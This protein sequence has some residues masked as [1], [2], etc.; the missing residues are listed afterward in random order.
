MNTATAET[1]PVPALRRLALVLVPVSAMTILSDFLFWGSE[2]GVSVGIFFAITGLMLLACLSE[3]PK[4]RTLAVFAALLA[5]CVQ[6][7][8]EV[9]LSNVLASIALTL[10]LA[11]EVFQP[12]LAPLWARVSEVLFGLASAPARWLGIAPLATRVALDARLPGFSLAGGAARAVWVLAPALLLLAVFGTIFA[13]SNAVFGEIAMRF[14]RNTLEWF[15]RLDL[16]FSRMLFWALVSTLALGI[17]HGTRAPDSPRWWTRTLPRL[18]RPDHRLALWQSGAVLLALN[19]IFFVVN[20]IDAVY[21][22]FGDGQLPKGVNHSEFVHAGVN[23]LIAAVVLSAIIIAGLFQ[24]EDRVVGGR[25]TKLLAHAWVLQNVVLIAGV[26][27]RLKLYVGE[28]MLTEKRV[29]VGCFLALVTAGFFIL[30]RFVEK[31]RSFNWLLGRNALATVA[32]FF[33]LQ[34][35]D[36]NTWIA[37]YNAQRWIAGEAR[38]VDLDYLASLG[39]G[40]WVPLAEIGRSTREPAVARSARFLLGASV[41]QD[42]VSQ[43]SA[44]WR[45]WQWRA[46]QRRRVFPASRRD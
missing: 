14:E 11:G 16:S 23:G 34:F 3:R 43:A 4:G 28:H 35:P 22:W 18:P 29:Y 42:A 40:A 27:L 26:F 2:A 9:S 32:L 38:W 24:Q 46:E 25:W 37:R 36:V 10:A 15:S 12:H 7:A 6:S 20:T 5:C 45:A 30:A 8:I 39:S 1:T 33:A 19:G 41:E 13:A 31:R 44:D 17:F 21:L